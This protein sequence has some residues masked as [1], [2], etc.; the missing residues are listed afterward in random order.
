MCP[1]NGRTCS[2]CDEKG[3][4]HFAAVCLSAYK[5]RNKCAT[6]NGLPMKFEVDTGA[7]ITAIPTNLHDEEVMGNL[8]QAKKQ[9][10]GLSRTKIVTYD[11]TVQCN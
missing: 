11:W 7:D 2:A 5:R 8:K 6:V 10:L 1:A 4:V 3:R 9:L